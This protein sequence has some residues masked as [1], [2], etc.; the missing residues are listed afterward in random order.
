MIQHLHRSGGFAHFNRWVM[1]SSQATHGDN[2]KAHTEFAKHAVGPLQQAIDR[3]LAA[4]GL[5]HEDLDVSS[6]PADVAQHASEA[7]ILF[8]D[9]VGANT[10][11][12]VETRTVRFGNHMECMEYLVAPKH[13]LMRTHLAWTGG[14]IGP[15]A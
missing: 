9:W 4:Q 2:F 6:M 10:S 5:Q 7:L 12:T 3:L 8:E 15:A 11:V 14:C 1:Y 13:N